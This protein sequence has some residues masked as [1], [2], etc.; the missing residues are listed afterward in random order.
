MG[1][2]KKV[3]MTVEVEV[4]VILPESMQV[5]T[6]DDLND[7]NACGFDVNNTDD[8]YIT[9]ARLLLLGYGRSNNDVFGDFK[10]VW[11]HSLKAQPPEQCYGDVERVSIVDDE[12]EVVN[13]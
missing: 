3:T 11:A 1:V 9:A 2:K 6:Q 7:I 12:V 8:L 10:S 5:L 13:L 4:E